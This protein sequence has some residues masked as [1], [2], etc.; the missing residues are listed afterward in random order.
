MKS[1]IATTDWS[2]IKKSQPPPGVYLI[3]LGEIAGTGVQVVVLGYWSERASTYMNAD[4][5]FALLETLDLTKYHA[6]TDESGNYISVDAQF[7]IA[8]D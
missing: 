1:L 6:I 4:D 3:I 8:A 2:D 7:T 5:G